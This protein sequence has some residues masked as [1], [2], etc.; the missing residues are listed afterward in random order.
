MSKPPRFDLLLVLL[1]TVIALASNSVTVATPIT[2]QF[3]EAP[4]F[5]NSSGCAVLVDEDESDGEASILC[6]DQAV[7][8]VM[9]LD[10]AYIRGSMATILDHMKFLSS[11]N[12]LD[13]FLLRNLHTST[14]CSLHV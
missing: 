6:S 10:T 5:Y 11:T 8:V 1:F 13:P 14:T 4:Q 3:K 2:Q 7:H 12:Y 9:T